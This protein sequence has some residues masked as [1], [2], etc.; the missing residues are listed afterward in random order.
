MDRVPPPCSPVTAT[1]YDDRDRTATGRNC[2]WLGLG[3]RER[4]RS[5]AEPG[6][7]GV[8]T[9]DGES[10]RN[11]KTGGLGFELKSGIATMKSTV[12]D[13]PP[14]SNKMVDTIVDPRPLSRGYRPS[15]GRDYSLQATE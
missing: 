15:L 10:H 6:R 1:F 8:D 4:Q 5:R 14:K 2:R 13:S 3:S 11:S 12:H 9:G 7:L